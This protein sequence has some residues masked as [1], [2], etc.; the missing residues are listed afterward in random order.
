[1]QVFRIAAF[2]SLVCAIH[3][4]PVEFSKISPRDHVR[5]MLSAGE[6]EGKVVSRTDSA[7]S[8]KIGQGTIECGPKDTLVTVQASKT[9]SIVRTKYHGQNAAA[10][11]IN[12]FSD[13]FGLLVGVEAQKPAVGAA[14]VAG[15]VASVWLLHRHRVRYTIFITE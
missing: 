15:A 2:A 10:G 14:L 7:L 5:L 6:C 12:T 13:I 9:R 11:A 8:I 3:A 1:M 4:A